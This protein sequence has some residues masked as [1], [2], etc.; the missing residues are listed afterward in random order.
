MLRLI[1]GGKD[2]ARN[3]GD[4][5]AAVGA[6]L[7]DRF[8]IESSPLSRL[9]RWSQQRIVVEN[10]AKLELVLEADDPTEHCYQNLIREIDSE[11]ETGIYLATPA[12]NAAQL[13]RLAGESGIS[14]RLYQQ[15]PKIAPILFEDE[16]KHSNENLDLVW[17]SI[18]AR[19][20]RA[21]LDA[22]VSE[23]ILMHLLESEDTA[24]DMTDALRAMLYTFHEDLARRRSG[25]PRLL[26]DRATRHLVVLV[27]ELSTRSGDYEER[28]RQISEKAGTA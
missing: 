6:Y 27:S 8:S 15:L 14:G 9:D 2:E 4:I 28:V 23:L 16:L 13:R 24:A 26:N 17:V 5:A 12:A 19:Y 18:E 11:A 7:S 21:N 22:E 3:D 20:D 10:Q 1:R 25:L